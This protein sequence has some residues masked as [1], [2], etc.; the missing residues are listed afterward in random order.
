MAKPKKPKG[1]NRTK[2]EAK[3]IECGAK[4]WIR[5]GEV[6]PGDMPTCQE[7]G[8]YGI[9]IATGKAKGG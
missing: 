1:A 6:E 8:C 2:A 7:E 4:R 9:M 3:C 5:A